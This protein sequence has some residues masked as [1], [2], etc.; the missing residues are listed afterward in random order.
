MSD[1]CNETPDLSFFTLEEIWSELRKRYD[2]VVLLTDEKVADLADGRMHTRQL[3]QWSG[4]PYTCYGL[5]SA[6][7]RNFWRNEI[8]EDWYEDED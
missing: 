2:A 5:L 7:T 3:R 4:S 1:P 6:F 8:V